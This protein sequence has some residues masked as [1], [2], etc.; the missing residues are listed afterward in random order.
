MICLATHHTYYNLCGSCNNFIIC[1][2][3]YND[4][5]LQRINNCIHCRHKIIK[6][7]YYSLDTL[8]TIIEYYKFTIIHILFNI[9]Y[10]NL[11]LY[12]YFPRNSEISNIFSTTIT[13]LFLVNNIS[14][15][16]IIPIIYSSS[17]YYYQ[18]SLAFAFVNGAYSLLF[19]IITNP[20]S[21]L[22]L[23]YIYYTTY[24]YILTLLQFSIITIFQLILSFNISR[25]HLYA[26]NNL[27]LIQIQNTH[28]NQVTTSTV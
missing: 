22:Q 7:F 12:I 28:F 1:K 13:H 8:Y 19:Y 27:Y 14:N 5:N 11:F 17:K 2:K 3:C 6:K 9:I 24:F 21:L 4:P 15:F 18:M 26:T 10:S 16:I 25:A 23:Y 20:K